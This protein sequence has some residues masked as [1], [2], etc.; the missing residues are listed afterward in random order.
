MA[1]HLI[2][3]IYYDLKVQSLYN[4]CRTSK[5]WPSASSML[6]SLASSS[7]AP[8]THQ[9][10]CCHRIVSPFL[11][12]WDFNLVPS[13]CSLPNVTWTKKHFLGLLKFFL[14]F[15]LYCWK[16]YIYRCPLFPSL[17]PSSPHLP[18]TLKSLYNLELLLPQRGPK[19]QKKALQKVNGGKRV[20]VQV[21]EEVRFL[22]NPPWPVGPGKPGIPVSWDAGYLGQLSS[23]YMVLA[24][25]ILEQIKQSSFINGFPPCLSEE[26]I[27]HSQNLSLLP[28]HL[29]CFL[30]RGICSTRPS[31]WPTITHLPST[32]Q[33]VV[34]LI[35]LIQMSGENF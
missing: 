21:E 22:W 1:F 5:A 30:F 11:D 29:S 18:F 25:L 4:T 15:N 19:E 35:S 3:K 6:S 27:K 9:A 28:S 23:V 7:L 10:C 17:T 12:S 32:A 33:M 24:P 34:C 14:I 2:K 13:L 31:L 16:S 20:R 8:R 26:I